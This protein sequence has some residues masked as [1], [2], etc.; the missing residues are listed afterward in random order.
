MRQKNRLLSLLICMAMM[1]TMCFAYSTTAYA[2]GALTVTPDKFESV[3]AGSVTVHDTPVVANEAKDFTCNIS[4]PAKGTLFFQYAAKD[5]ASCYTLSDVT[6]AKR[7]GGWTE[8]GT[9]IDMYY[10][11]AK[12]TVSIKLRVYA[13][14]TDKKGYATFAAYYCAGAKSVGTKSS[15]LLGSPGSGK[16]STFTVKV[17]STGYLK[18]T[19]NN[20][21]NPSYSVNLK[22]NGYKGYN[23]LSSY[24][25]YTEY[26]GVKKGTYTIKLQGA[27]MYNVSV[28]F[29]KVKETSNKTTKKKAA[30]IKKKKLNKG[31]IVT[32]K[33]KA[34]WYKI[35]NPKKQ[36]M[37]I[38]VN[39]K[40]ASSG[41][42]S[43]KVKVTIVYPNGDKD[44]STVSPGYSTDFTVTYGT[45]YGKANK[46]TYYLKIESEN[47]GN[48]YYT[49]KW[50]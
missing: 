50:K 36:K 37:T 44:S 31:I 32:N 34:H 35:K 38:A 45:T 1:L 39:A 27:A 3:E 11:S 10:V 6:G 28:K 15:F 23:Y 25:S 29:V 12:Q 42:S 22:A 41:G 13:Y 4:M 2:E 26:I 18:V 21:I 46:G 16:D 5:D 40:K 48:G 19:A 49:I 14:G 7:A 43:G 33:K 17:P 30:T 20:E 47:G 24:N 8:N 9:N